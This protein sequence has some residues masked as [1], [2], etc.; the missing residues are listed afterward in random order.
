MI[1]TRLQDF[2]ERAL[3]KNVVEEHPQ[4]ALFIKKYFEYISRELGEHDLNAHLLDYL[5]V[6]KT[7]SEF[8]DDFKSK[9]APL[10]PEKYK[11]SLSHIV[12]NIPSFYQS[13]GTEESFAAFF[14]MVFNT[15][16]DIYYPKVDMLRVSDGKWIEPYYLS[17]L[18]ETVESMQYFYDKIIEGS[19]SGAK[20]YV[21]EITYITDPDDPGQQILVASLI[22]RDGVFL[23]GDT[24]TVEGEVSPSFTLDTSGTH[25]VIVLPG[26]W[27]NDDG[28]VSWN[29]FIQD[30]YYYQDYSYVLESDIPVS[31]YEK[32]V[33]E[34]IHPAGMKF[35]GSLVEAIPVLD[36]GAALTSYV[37]WI[38]EWLNQEIIGLTS[39]GVTYVL[40]ETSSPAHL[41][42]G[43][44]YN[45]KYF[46][47][48]REARPFVQMYSPEAL[49]SVPIN[50]IENNYSENYMTVTLDGTPTTAYSV[51][52][53][54][55]TLDAPLGSQVTVLVTNN[56][57]SAP[58][59]N[60][61]YQYR[62]DIGESVFILPRIIRRMS[63]A[64]YY[65]IVIT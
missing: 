27:A 10:I 47:A 32:A 20:A 7:V 44:D 52:N 31:V 64:A 56:D 42:S 34:N 4:F 16:V 62:G 58:L 21:E 5:D 9:Y 54:R 36:I 22:D 45:W 35:F 24:L 60:K 50:T 51:L 33:L 18:G 48:N 29:K 37:D 28:K 8:Y 63:I 40:S 39:Q 13:K 49:G 55:L 6:D 11:A 65:P 41:S 17:P 43:N 19:V 23:N 57:P 53:D 2:V 25:G 30:S 26:Y 14:R 15:T 1:A 3:P 46:E 59:A 38:I 12:K 61:T